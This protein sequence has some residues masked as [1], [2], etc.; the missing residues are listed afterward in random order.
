MT[1]RDVLELAGGVPEGRELQ[2]IL[3]GGA[4]GAFVGPD[5]LDLELT[6]EATRA[7]GAT[8]GSGVIMVLRRHRRPRADAAAHRRVL[9]RRVVRPVRAVPGR[10]R[11][12]GGGARCGSRTAARA[13]RVDD[14]LALLDEIARGMRDAS[15]CGLGQTA[16]SA[17]ESAIRAL[18]PFAGAGA[19]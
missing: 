12:P 11:A 9:P 16:S 17:I 7:A 3:L 13:A 15:I 10:H 1:L 6:F 19:A 18:R 5:M 8:L 4:A 2:A 14:E